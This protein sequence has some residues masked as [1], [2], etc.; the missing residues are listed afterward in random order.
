MGM[1]RVRFGVWCPTCQKF[2]KRLLK[3]TI[4]MDYYV[5]NEKVRIKAINVFCRECGTFLYVPWVEDKNIRAAYKEYIKMKNLVRPHE[6]NRLMKKLGVG[7]EELARL[8]DVPVIEIE[9][10]FAGAIP[11]EILT[12]RVRKALTGETPWK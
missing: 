10:V 5:R 7:K 11:S 3:K 1:S 9:R 6:I 2:V 4:E 12:V 8:L